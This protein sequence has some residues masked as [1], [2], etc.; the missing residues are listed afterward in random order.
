[1]NYQI[2]SDLQFRALLKNCF[3]CFH[4]D[5]R[6]T[7]NEKISLVSDITLF[8]FMFKKASNIH[9][10]PKRRYKIIASR[11]TEIPFYG[12]IG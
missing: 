12:G 5:L 9:F 4:F 2:L 10:K 6:D 1:M 8:V 3:Q 11:Q 7:S